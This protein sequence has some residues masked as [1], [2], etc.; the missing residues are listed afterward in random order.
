M[1][2]YFSYHGML[3]GKTLFLEKQLSY[4]LGLADQPVLVLGA[5]VLSSSNA[6]VIMS[7]FCVFMQVGLLTSRII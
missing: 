6:A 4:E 7:C 2:S 3:N 1:L 5:V